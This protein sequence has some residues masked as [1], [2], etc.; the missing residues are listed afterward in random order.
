MRR[1]L[2][3]TQP[4]SPFVDFDDFI[5]RDRE[6]EITKIRSRRVERDQMHRVFRRR[7]AIA[8]A[9]L[10]LPVAGF[11][12]AGKFPSDNKQASA[13]TTAEPL[14][15]TAAAVAAT[16]VAEGSQPFPAPAEVRAVHF[17]MYLANDQQAIQKIVDAYD[18]DTGLNAV[19]LDVKNESGEIGFTEGMPSLAISSGAAQNYYEPRL[20]VEQ[21]H[22]AGF[23][24]IGRV[25]SFE[26]PVIAE[27]APK[28]AIRTK[29]GAVWKNNA[30]LGWMN[31][32]AKANWTYLTDIAKAAGKV[33]FDEIQFDY[34]RF[35][36]DG[37]LSNVKLDRTTAKMDSTIAAFLKQ[38][39]D[40]L[41]PLK[42]RVSADLF[43]LAAT[44]DLGIG[45]N[46]RKLANIVDVMSPM[47]YPQGYASG[48]YNITCPICNPHDLVAATMRDWQKAIVG[49]TAELRPWIQAY[50]WT[51]HPYGPVQVMAQVTAL[52][53]FTERGFL[54]WDAKSVYDPDL[55]RFPAAP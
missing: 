16:T 6:A 26:D 38:A 28:R 9:V 25:V 17:S 51:G 34:V 43:G 7:R 41:H 42:L 11:V 13:K 14:A 53:D 35:P 40:E 22:A 45:Q 24:V 18:A 10:V 12:F 31:P 4:G 20:I 32:Y 30:G 52:R 50:D 44:R 3:A 29:D 5:Q 54:L 47:I 19:E 55:L 36:T 33:G 49:G 46:P 1:S 15:A 2:Y 39:V 37:D 23:Y 48:E 21:L 8:V 27:K